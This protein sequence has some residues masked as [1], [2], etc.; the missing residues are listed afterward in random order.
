[1]NQRKGGEWPC[2]EDI[3]IYQPPRKYGAGIELATPGSAVRYASVVRHVTDYAT[4]PGPEVLDPPLVSYSY[5]YVKV[6][7]CTFLRRNL[8]V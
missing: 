6:S 4:Q 1:M 2:V 3:S 8:F 5:A 7:K